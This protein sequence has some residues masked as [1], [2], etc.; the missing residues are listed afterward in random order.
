MTPPMN[1]S[2]NL[3]ALLKKFEGCRLV[4]YV[5]RPGDVYT[6]GYGHT[7]NVHP[8]MTIT[9]SEADILAG[10][11]LKAAVAFVNHY[12][13]AH[14]TQEEFDALTDFV[15]NVGAGSF[16]KS[17]MLLYINKGLLSQAAFEFQ[18]WDHAGGKVMAGLLT[19]RLAEENLFKEGWS[20]DGEGKIVSPEE[21]TP[22]V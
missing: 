8:G 1:Y 5:P 10:V 16:A 20:Q 6:I 4:A 11:D 14:L 2:Q 19:R 3:L 18:K 9:Q 22:N 17:T 13:T 7:A 12:V 15:F 21:A